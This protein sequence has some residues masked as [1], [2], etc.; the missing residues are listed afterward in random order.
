MDL[1]K[2]KLGKYW[3]CNIKPLWDVIWNIVLAACVQGKSSGNSVMRWLWLWKQGRGV[4][5]ETIPFGRSLEEAWFPTWKFGTG[6]WFW[7]VV[8][9]LE[10]CLFNTEKRCQC[11]KFILF[12]PCDLSVWVKWHRKHKWHHWLPGIRSETGRISSN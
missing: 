8:V 12:L 2:E 7:S 3:S 4:L 9:C 5:G 1:Q 6:N 11:K 10:F